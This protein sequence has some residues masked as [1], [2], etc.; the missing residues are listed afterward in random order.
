M[1]RSKNLLESQF[2]IELEFKNHVIGI[3]KR[4]SIKKIISRIIDD[5]SFKTIHLPA[6]ISGLANPNTS[7]SLCQHD[8]AS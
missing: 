3:S 7:Q 5:L 2:I 4:I 8:P 6:S 1:N